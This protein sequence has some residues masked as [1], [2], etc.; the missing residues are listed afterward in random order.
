MQIS[1]SDLLRLAYAP[2][3]FVDQ[4]TRVFDSREVDQ[5][6]LEVP[7]ADQPTLAR[8]EIVGFQFKRQFNRGKIRFQR[9]QLTRLDFIRALAENKI[10]EFLDPATW[11][12]DF[13]SA[14][15]RAGLCDYTNSKISLS[16]YFAEIHSI[17]ECEQVILHEIAHGICGKAAGHSKR[18][19]NTATSIGYRAEQ[20]SG[21][22]IAAE[23][24]R[25]VGL[26]PN[27]HAH[28]RYRKPSR[29]MSCA[30][31]SSSFSARFLISWRD[32]G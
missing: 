7:V 26:C 8:L 24:A 4:L 10:A 2:E 25:W 19:L 3:Q 16:R 9:L 13:D 11:S 22:E 29:P 27:G 6:D 21:K 12:F 18:W 5:F 23:T 15:R 31:C 17:D 14:K 20:F 28:Y 32:R 1:S 30:L